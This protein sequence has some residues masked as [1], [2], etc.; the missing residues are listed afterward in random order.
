MYQNVPFFHERTSGSQECLRQ[1]NGN[2]TPKRTQTKKVSNSFWLHVFALAI[3]FIDVSD[4]ESVSEFSIIQ[5]ST[6]LLLY[7]FFFLLGGS[8]GFFIQKFRHSFTK[9]SRSWGAKKKN[10]GEMTHGDQKNQLWIPS[11]LRVVKHGLLE[12]LTF[13]YP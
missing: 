1:E 11:T 5:P 6:K 12:I 10:H 13:P 4:V 2:H 7:Q 9:W 8:Y 3:L